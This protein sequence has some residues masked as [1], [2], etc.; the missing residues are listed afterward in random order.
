MAETPHRFSY[1]AMTTQFEVIIAGHKHEYARQASGAVFREI[2][3]LN[4]LLNKYDAGSDI[5]QVN[6]ATPGTGSILYPA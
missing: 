4:N 2:D 6:L 1:E 5:G 3:R